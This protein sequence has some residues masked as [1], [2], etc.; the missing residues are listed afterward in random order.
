MERK[1]EFCS[2]QRNQVRTCRRKS[3]SEA[4]PGSP[5]ASELTFTRVAIPK[6]ASLIVALLESFDVSS[7]FS[8]LISLHRSDQSKKS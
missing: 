2:G 3:D 7:K 6:S 1:L 8:G 4:I 5:R